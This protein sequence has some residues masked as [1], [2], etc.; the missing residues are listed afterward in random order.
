MAIASAPVIIATFARFI[1][2]IKFIKFIKFITFAA[3]GWTVVLGGDTS[4][5]PR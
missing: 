5:T 3:T 2:F 4:F 1:T